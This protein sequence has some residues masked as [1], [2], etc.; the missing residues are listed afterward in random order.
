[1]KFYLYSSVIVF[2]S[3]IAIFSLR[4]VFWFSLITYRSKSFRES[5]LLVFNFCES[6]RISK[7]RLIWQ[8]V[9]W[10]LIIVLGKMI[11]LLMTC[12]YQVQLRNLGRDILA[13]VRCQGKGLRYMRMYNIFY[14]I[15]KS[16]FLWD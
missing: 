10:I 9:S 15:F 2:T 1:M 7:N 3:Y 4:V 14:S 8:L 11:Y 16:S 6:Y 13:P 12:Q 5:D